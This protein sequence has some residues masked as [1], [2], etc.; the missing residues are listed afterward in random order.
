MSN[1]PD[2]DDRFFLAWSNMA[3]RL[4]VDPF[5][6]IR[7]AFSE[8]D[9]RA[10]AHNPHG[11]AS[12]VIQFM[13]KTLTGLGWLKTHEEFR[14]LQAADQ[15]PFVE[16]YFRPH[17]K[18]LT[19]DA[20]VYVATFLPALC[21]GASKG[22]PSYVLCAI[23]E[24]DLMHHPAGLVSTLTQAYRWNPVLDRVKLDGSQGRD[25]RITV[26]DLSH[27]LEKRCRGARYH[28]IVARLRQAMG[29][30]PM[31]LPEP[32][33]SAPALPA[34]EDEPITQP[35]SRSTLPWGGELGDD[36][37]DAATRAITERNDGD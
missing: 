31:P 34:V 4:K 6:L 28:A 15:V 17:A 1:P 9:C 25:G 16:R 14:K 12:G 32:E 8:S 30:Q 7:V 27:H 21:P 33:P 37:A 26:G 24:A 36:I 18:W 11:H 5:D 23:D 29:L 22:G 10:N 3:D 19:S 13:P 20:M 2:L 35:S